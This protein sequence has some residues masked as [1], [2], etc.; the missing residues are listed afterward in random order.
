MSDFVHTQIDD[1]IKQKSELSSDLLSPDLSLNET[2]ES[3]DIKDEIELVSSDILEPP[4]TPPLLTHT[5]SLHNGGKKVVA[6]RCLS[7]KKLVTF[8]VQ[9]DEDDVKLHVRFNTPNQYA[10]QIFDCDALPTQIEIKKAYTVGD[11][12]D[13]K[14]LCNGSHSN[15]YKARFA[16]ENSDS[17]RIIILKVLMD[18]S[19][20]H[21]V[22]KLEFKRES[23]LLT[24]M[25]HVNII[26]IIG[27][28]LVDSKIA[29]VFK[30]PMIA[31]EA[32]E[33]DTLTYHLSLR[34]SFY[35]SPF[36]ESRYMRMAKE[37]ACALKYIHNELDPQCTMVHR[38]LKPDNIGFAKDGTL[39]LMDFGLAVC[40]C[41]GTDHEGTYQLTGCTGSLRYMAPE[42]AL[43]K[44]YNEKV[45]I[46]SFGMILY[47]IITGV[48]PFS[49]FKKEKFYQE[50]V[51]K[52]IRP[53]LG[54]D[55]Y[56]R[57]VKMKDE[58][59]DLSSST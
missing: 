56:G 3:R 14:H 24:K 7:A 40:L 39:K 33:G 31:L 43:S 55:D 21:E 54:Y 15:V 11:F 1:N 9:L 32:L 18:T 2:D 26:R 41:K 28:G 58:I 45:D 10:L 47:Q 48:T 13:I 25:Q 46:Y 53:G 38:D 19:L 57:E 5:N 8:D 42:V 52:R 23:F 17:N 35:V 50:V 49:G 44:P 12:T 27:T 36:T 16:S 51:H 6:G 30:R 20:Q 22:A 29:S 59:K 37:F 34:R 4:V